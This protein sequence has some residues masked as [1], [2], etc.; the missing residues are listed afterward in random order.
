MFKSPLCFLKCFL[1][2]RA[3]TQFL[4]EDSADFTSSYRRLLVV[5]RKFLHDPITLKEN[6][7]RQI[8]SQYK[9]FGRITREIMLL[10]AAIESESSLRFTPDS[11]APRFYLWHQFLAGS[12]GEIVSESEL[13]LDL[14]SNLEQ[15][16]LIVQET[17]SVAAGYYEYARRVIYLKLLKTEVKTLLEA[18]STRL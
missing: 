3:I 10:L 8:E 9:T 7:T 12:E 4:S 16:C 14:F 6:T 1:R 2:K 11:Q 5:C 18:L 17:E 13:W 15:L